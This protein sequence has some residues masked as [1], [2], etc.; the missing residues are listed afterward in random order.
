MKLF[1]FNER[2]FKA[3][4]IYEPQTNQRD[5]KW[6][7]INFVYLFGYA[8]LIIV[9]GAFLLFQAK[10]AV[11]YGLAFYPF[12]AAYTAGS[13]VLVTIWKKTNIF[14]VIRNFEKFIEKSEICSF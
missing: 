2:N 1:Q 10:S 14:H 6:N 9:R 5:S 8:H 4:G 12:V 7:W 3:M 13:A 11:E